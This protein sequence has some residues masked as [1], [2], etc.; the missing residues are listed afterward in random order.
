VAKK[1]EEKQPRYLSDIPVE[2]GEVEVKK[3]NPGARM[4]DEYGNIEE[5]KLS[6]QQK[7]LIQP[8]ALMKYDEPYEGYT[9]FLLAGGRR[10][11]AY[12]ELKWKQIPARIYPD[13]LDGLEIR[14]IELEE[15]IRRKDMSDAEKL[16]ATKQIHDLW[17]SM[18]GEK[19]STGKGASG[20]SLRDTAERLNISVGKASMDVELAE[21]L[22]EM[23]EL[24]KFGTAAEIRKAIKNAKKKVVRDEKVEAYEA[25]MEGTEDSELLR[26][27]E[28]SYIIGDFFQKI[29]NVPKETIDLVDL[30]IDY[31][32]DIDEDSPQ[33]LQA[34]EDKKKGVY[35]VVSKKDFPTI[36]QRTL[37]E[38]YRVMKQ[39]SWIIIWFGWEYFSH[40][41]QWA[42][43]VGFNTSW[44]T[45]K[46]YKGAGYG[47][48]RNPYTYLGHT[49]EPF[50]YFRKGLADIRTP[51]ADTF[52]F[53]PIPPEQ[54]LHPYEKPLPLMAA[55]LDTFIDPG[56]RVLLPYAGSGNTLISAFKYKCH[57]IGF[58]T[59]EEYKKGYISKLKEELG[60]ELKPQNNKEGSTEDS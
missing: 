49:V 36:M 54:R 52:E 21:R 40:I 32:M 29:K 3:V 50:F 35:K 24:A 31:P 23:P 45:G 33:H 26:M 30:D 22:E 2:Q 60:S 19:T 55:I 51:H 18:Y 39:D 1:K 56:S 38:C 15:N 53:P 9:H 46:W 58:D 8:I 13:G 20:H 34:Q 10:L 25:E 59:S 48:T 41:Q 7:G 57:G 42:K 11:R 17:V 12:V 44:Y 47:H 6:I 43:L 4:R 28:K 37:Q 5:L 27:Y 16:K 14:Q